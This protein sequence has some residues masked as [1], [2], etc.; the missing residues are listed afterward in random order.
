MHHRTRF[1]VLALT[2]PLVLFTVVGGLLGQ[3]ASPPGAYPQLRMFDDVV[4]LIFGNYVEEPEPA[5]VLEGAMRGLADALDA[6]SSFLTPG[7]IKVLEARTPPPTGESG[8]AL[9]RQFGLRVVAARE[10]SPADRAGLHTG[11]YLRSIDGRLTRHMSLYEGERLLHGPVGKKVALVV[12]RGMATETHEV[13]L[14]LAAASQV[15]VT[16][17]LASPDVGLVRVAA[18]TE[19][20]VSDVEQQVAQLRTQGV[21]SLIVDVRHTADGD[22]EA[23][24]ALARLFVPS[25]TLAIREAR[26]A[27]QERVEAQPGDGAIT[28]PLTL[29]TSN[30]TSRAA[31]VFAAAIVDNERGEIVGE[32][33]LGRASAQKLIKLPDGTGLWLTYLRWLSPTG[34]AIHGTGLTPEVA[35]SEPDRE[36]GAPRPTEDPILDKALERITARADA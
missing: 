17:R 28:L 22:P 13:A 10:G 27:G 34:T 14:T 15:G 23:G 36:F 26:G 5:D 19:R 2:T 4:S 31:E 35:V 6:D 21:A 30:G 1:L 7:D 9:T 8:L 3:Q 11:D 29:L 24:V 32:R 33:T 20:T 18:F 25:G 12:Q 16:S